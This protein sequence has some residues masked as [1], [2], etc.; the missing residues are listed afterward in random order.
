MKVF[1]SPERQRRHRPRHFLVAGAPQ[2]SPE[3]PERLDRLL[4]AST[5]TAGKPSASSTIRA[6]WKPAGRPSGSNTTS[7][8]C[9]SSHAATRYMAA[10]RSTWRRFSSS[11]RPR[12]STSP[13][14]GYPRGR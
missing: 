13:L 11:K 8:I 7:P 9:S 1:C 6:V 3:G 12:F 5:T 10:M 14:T 4:A 2:P